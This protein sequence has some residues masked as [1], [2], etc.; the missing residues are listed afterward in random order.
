VNGSRRDPWPAA[1]NSAS[2]R[3][4]HRSQRGQ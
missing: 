3:T 2:G 1:I 4:A